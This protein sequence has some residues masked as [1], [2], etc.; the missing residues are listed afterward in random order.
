MRKL[1]T[2]L[3]VKSDKKCQSDIKNLDNLIWLANL[4]IF[5][6]ASSPRS[7]DDWI[8]VYE[9]YILPGDRLLSNF[10]RELAVLETPTCK[11]VEKRYSEARSK[12]LSDYESFLLRNYSKWADGDPSRPKMVTDIVN[13]INSLLRTRDVI[14]LIVYDGMRVDFWNVLRKE[15]E[16][17]F[18]ISEE[19]ILSVIPSETIFS[20]RAIFSGS[21]PKDLESFD[22][23]VLLRKRVKAPITYMIGKIEKFD[24]LLGKRERVRVLVYGLLDEIGHYFQEGLSIALENF[25]LIAQR[26]ARFYEKIRYRLSELGKVA[27][28]IASDHGFVQTSE[29]KQID[30]PPYV[31]WLYPRFNPRFVVFG[32]RRRAIAAPYEVEDLMNK[33]EEKDLG[34]F[35]KDP[36]KLKIVKEDG[37]IEVSSKID[38]QVPHSLFLVF[39]K[40]GVRFFKIGLR[41]PPEFA[42]GG[43]SPHET[44]VPFAVLEPK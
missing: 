44:I 32:R 2:W 7:W 15:L 42:H 30:L 35:V 9:E 38:K 33:L 39:A 34:H 31:D 5:I 27:I 6:S 22:E 17:V 10:K 29:L 1:H 18:K 8:K 19:R 26:H 11:T 14:F 37:S 23:Y 24:E 21:F 43:I 3:I 13:E 36:K 20:R 28:V 4:A 41:E 25:K 12:V 40:S 16:K